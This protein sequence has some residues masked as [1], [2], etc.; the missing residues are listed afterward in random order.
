MKPINN[1][2]KPI[3]NQMKPINNQMKP[4]GSPLEERESGKLDLLPGIAGS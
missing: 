3:N 2:M 1:R 4:S